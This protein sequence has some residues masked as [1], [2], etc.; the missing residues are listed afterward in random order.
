[1]ME[2]A[3][4]GVEHIRAAGLYA[5]GPYSAGEACADCSAASRVAGRRSRLRRLEITRRNHVPAS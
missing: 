1:M 5:V 4:E 2:G 3:G